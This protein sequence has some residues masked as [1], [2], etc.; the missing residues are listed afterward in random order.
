MKCPFW[1]TLVRRTEPR[2]DSAGKK[3][4]E[5]VFFELSH[6]D[7]KKAD[8]QL[9]DKESR[10]CSIPDANKKQ[11]QIVENLATTLPM[12][13]KSDFD[14]SLF[15]KAEMLSV[16]VSSGLTHL[17]D[18]LK[19]NHETLT[20]NLERLIKETNAQQAEIVRQLK[21]T[22]EREK[23]L[24]AT[25]TKISTQLEVLGQLASKI[26]TVSKRGEV[27]EKALVDVITFLTKPKK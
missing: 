16:V 22:P 19:G 4:G 13:L 6:E 7:C 5:E 24:L 9:Y 26:D 3:I 2:C 11:A 21:E 17:Q 25:L 23:A 10:L 27:L 12:R 18:A 20:K 1:H 14:K 15:E 8:C